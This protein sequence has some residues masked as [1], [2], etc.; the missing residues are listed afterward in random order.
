M[1]L[2]FLLTTVIYLVFILFIHFYL[3]QFDQP[4][5]IIVSDNEDI[6][7]DLVDNSENLNEIEEIDYQKKLEDYE[8][9]LADSTANNISNQDNELIIKENE[10]DGINNSAN[11]E[12]LKYLDVEDFEKE[13]S[14]QSLVQEVPNNNIDITDNK[15]VN[16]LD[17][18][19]TN[20]KDEQYNFQAVTNELANPE[21]YSK[22]GLLN[23]MNK[24]TEDRV[25]DDVFA[26]DEFTQS[27][28]PL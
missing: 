27:Y 3:K 2:D 22:K 21:S 14:C 18:Y 26:F 13:T 10:L 23:D 5:S 16:E 9:Q 1:D 20:M 17:K 19:F 4:K 15:A 11:D 12:L 28:A 7:T 6:D 24:I 8:K 25:Y